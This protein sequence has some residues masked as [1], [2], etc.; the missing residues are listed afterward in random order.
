[1]SIIFDFNGTIIFDKPIVEESWQQFFYNHTGI[2]YPIEQIN[3]F[4][5][6]FNPDI[7]IR[8]I[9]KND[10]TKEQMQKL[11]DEKEEI[12]R[13]LCIKYKDDI[14]KLAS[15][16]E[17][18][19]D[20]LK[21]RKIHC[22]IAT[23]APKSNVDFFFES[24]KLDRWFKREETIC[25]D[26][27]FPGKPNPEIFLRAAKRI[28]ADIK[29]CI[30]FEDA[31]SGIKAAVNSKAKAVVGVASLLNRQQLTDLG[32]DIIIDDYKNSDSLLKI[33]IELLN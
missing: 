27:S 21:R 6:G 2:R 30:I 33:I 19:L 16:V 11:I 20:E 15:G 3:S 9:L 10:F 8:H 22:T 29:D 24:L 5:H 18:F 25:S 12:Y 28:N 1:M 17:E 31:E 13:Q 4:I 23:G 26:H 7:T 14:Y 32:A